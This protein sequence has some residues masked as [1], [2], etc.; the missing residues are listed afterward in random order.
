MA[1][2]LEGLDRVQEK[3]IYDIFYARVFNNSL[4]NN[5]LMCCIYTEK[6]NIYY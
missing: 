4:G 5:K 6:Q 2:Y 3:T 1:I